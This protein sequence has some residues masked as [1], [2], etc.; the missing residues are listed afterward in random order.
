MQHPDLLALAHSVLGRSRAKT[1]DT[2]WDTR[3]TGPQEVSQSTF[4]A[5]TAKTAQIQPESAGVPLSHALGAGTPGQCEKPGTPPG[6]PVGQPYSATL[7]ALRWRCPDL[8]EAGRWRDA[9]SDAE[10]FLSAWGPQAL[11]LGWTARELFGLHKVPERPAP[12]YC[13]LSRYDETGLI[14]CLRRRPVIALTYADG[15]I[16]DAGSVVIYR[17]NR[18][19]ALGPVGDSLDDLW[20]LGA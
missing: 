4:G 12:T 17:K 16:Q 9:I 3:G 18:N 15:A 5:G 10:S 6:T 1:W 2:A 14:W 11:A 7:T 8:I 19:P 20:G 13:R